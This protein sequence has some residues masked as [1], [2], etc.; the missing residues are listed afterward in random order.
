[1]PTA[2]P[3][4][5]YDATTQSNTPARH[6][7]FGRP[8]QPAPTPVPGPT[9]VPF[10]GKCDCDPTVHFSQHTTCTVQR[11]RFGM[12]AL[13]VHYH[14]HQ[15]CHP[16]DPEFS[17]CNENIVSSRARS[18]EPAALCRPRTPPSMH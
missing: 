3:T 14:A 9:P 18:D 15:M 2:P 1:V 16:L 10:T 13:V 17:K 8:P 4:H 11:N 5:W 6:N 7:A 12:M